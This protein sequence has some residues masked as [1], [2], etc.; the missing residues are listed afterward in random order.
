MM[1]VEIDATNSYLLII[2][3]YYKFI[4]LAPDELFP[5]PGLPPRTGEQRFLSHTPGQRQRATRQDR[6]HQGQYGY[7]FLQFSVQC[8]NLLFDSILSQSIAGWNR[9]A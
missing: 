9:S 1:I 7:Y 3:A 2:D 5:R 4:P 8:F 6:E